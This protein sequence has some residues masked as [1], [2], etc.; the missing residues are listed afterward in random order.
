LR[1]VTPGDGDHTVAYHC[2]YNQDS[3][4]IEMCDMPSD[5]KKRWDD[6]SHRDMEA[7]TADLVA[8]L[9]LAYGIPVR[10]VNAADLRKGKK[11]ITTHAEMSQAYHKSTHWD[12]GAWRRVRFM[13]R[14][15]A[16]VL[17]LRAGR[18]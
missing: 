6:K 8:R 18:K 13:S 17:L 10:Y 16:R 9:C 4:G 11:G 3:I 5:A 14:V 7:L 1:P 15:R 12:P 2:G